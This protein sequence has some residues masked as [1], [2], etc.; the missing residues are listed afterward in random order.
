M[1]PPIEPRGHTPR[2][3]PYVLQ[4]VFLILER[5]VEGFC[6]VLPEEMA[7]SS[8]QCLPV[9]HQCFDTQCIYC[10]GKSFAGRFG[11]L[12]DRHR[13]VILSE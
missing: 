11:P 9:L 3:G 12:D 7:R 2:G 6:K 10:A 1:S 4:L 5:T 8:L 13:H